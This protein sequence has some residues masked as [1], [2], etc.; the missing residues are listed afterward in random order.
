MSLDLT[1]WI[2]EEPKF[3][4]LYKIGDDLQRNKQLE[5]QKAYRQQQLKDKDE[6]RQAGDAKFLTNY[7]NK[8]DNLT[9]T[10]YDNNIND[11][12]GNALKQAYTLSAQKVPLG[13]IMMAVQPLV[14]KVNTYQ[15]KAKMYSAQKKEVLDNL[16]TLKGYNLQAI[17]DEMDKKAF[18]D[19]DP[20]TGQP[21][22]NVDKAEPERN[23]ALDVINEMPERVT[24]STSIDDIVKS[25]EPNTTEGVRKYTNAKGGTDYRKT[26]IT[27]APYMVNEGGEVVPKYEIAKDGDMQVEHLF[28]NGKGGKEKH[29]VRLLDQDTFTAILKKYPAMADFLKG[30]IRSAGQGNVDL[31]SEQANHAAR[32][33]LYTELK[34]NTPVK[35]KDV[36]V[37]KENPI[38]YSTNIYLGGINDVY[39]GIENKVNEDIVSGVSEGKDPNNR[40]TR[41]NSLNSDAAAIV[42]K[43]VQ[44]VAPNSKLGID[45]LWLHKDSNGKISI[46]RLNEDDRVELSEK[47]KLVTMPRVGT[48]LKAQPSV[49]EKR[50]VIEQGNKNTA[51]KTNKW[52]RYKAK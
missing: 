38:H 49:Q 36:E 14:D 32:A 1:G 30:Q 37:T 40:Y 20:N 27:A 47:Y 12:L 29:A 4:G 35:Y 33:I 31:Y 45:K 17:S 28:D 3:E 5:E 43:M 24:N 19:I 2:N 16:K 51:P 7:L 26:E 44:E 50:V 42:T 15:S 6:A 41:A 18:Y 34:N 52:D 11:L 48:N 13:N 25:Y 22:L 46:Y 10:L 21:I 9:G 39:S 23:Y 8:K